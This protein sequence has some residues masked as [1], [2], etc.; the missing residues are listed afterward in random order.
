MSVKEET[1]TATGL[2]FIITDKNKSP[3][4]ISSEYEIEQKVWKMEKIK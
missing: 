3:Y 4:F 2:K 1:V